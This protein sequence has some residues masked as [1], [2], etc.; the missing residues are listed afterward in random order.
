MGQAF[1]PVPRC[2]HRTFYPS[3]YD[4]FVADY[5]SLLTDCRTVEDAYPMVQHIKPEVSHFWTP[6]PPA[7]RDKRTEGREREAV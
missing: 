5:V 1:D 3:D 2:Y 7:K 6:G 4:A